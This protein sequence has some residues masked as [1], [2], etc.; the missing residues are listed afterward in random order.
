[1]NR[2]SKRIQSYNTY[3]RTTTRGL[4][5]AVLVSIPFNIRQMV[6]NSI[7]NGDVVFR[8]SNYLAECVEDENRELI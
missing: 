7:R 1:M 6:W 3:T 4:P 2:I 5:K 8:I